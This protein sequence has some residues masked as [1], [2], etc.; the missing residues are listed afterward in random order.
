[1]KLWQADEI[2][3]I[4][5]AT[6]ADL[7]KQRMAPPFWAFPWAGGQGV[8]RYILDHPEIVRGRSVLDVACGSGLLA[9]AAAAAGAMH[10]IANDIDPLCEAAVSLN[11]ETNGV[12]IEWRGGNLL[13]SGPPNVHVI[14]AGDVFYEQSMSASFLEWFSHKQPGT[15]V[16]AGDP[17]R[18]YAPGPHAESIAEYDITTTL[19][20]ESTLSRK[21]RVWR[22]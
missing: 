10:V 15:L 21:A 16:L 13:L 19:D 4:W 18:A 17:G 7:E 20:L 11:A 6:E 5:S 8:A 3:P 12:R 1:M 9:I 22:F 14:L 2:T